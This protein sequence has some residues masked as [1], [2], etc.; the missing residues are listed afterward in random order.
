MIFIIYLIAG[1]SRLIPKQNIFA[2]CE[3]LAISQLS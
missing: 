2:M 3:Q 1:E